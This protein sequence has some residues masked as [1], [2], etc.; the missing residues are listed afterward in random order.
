MGTVFSKIIRQ[1]SSSGTSKFDGTHSRMNG[2]EMSFGI[3][4]YLIVFLRSGRTLEGT[5]TRPDYLVNRVPKKLRGHPGK[6]N[7]SEI[8]K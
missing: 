8:E 6:K 3:K 4:T 1:N 2:T 5:G 7:C